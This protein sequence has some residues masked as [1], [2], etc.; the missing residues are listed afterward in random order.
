MILLNWHDGQKSASF[1]ENCLQGNYF[2]KICSQCDQVAI[3][4]KPCQQY[5]DENTEECEIFLSNL[6]KVCM[7]Q[8]PL[9]S[10]G[11]VT[12]SN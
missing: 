3:E 6:R 5:R 4:V 12:F 10:N 1:G 2:S 9:V 7:T 8:Q 11:F